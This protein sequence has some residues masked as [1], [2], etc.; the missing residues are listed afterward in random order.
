MVDMQAEA[1]AP[2]VQAPILWASRKLISSNPCVQAVMVLAEDGKVLAHERA[3]GYD[4]IDFPIDG[5]Y[6][7][8]YQAPGSGLVFY[9]RTSEDPTSV[10]FPAQIGK[11]IESLS[12][13]IT[14]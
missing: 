11:I 6:T 2:F 4:D 10:N 3:V 9:I 8:I 14:R 1:R 5:G 7:L 12:P 13:L